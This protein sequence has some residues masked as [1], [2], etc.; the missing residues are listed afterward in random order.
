MNEI[1]MKKK[2][3]EQENLD[4]LFLYFLIDSLK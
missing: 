4:I 1:K 3:G 2:Q